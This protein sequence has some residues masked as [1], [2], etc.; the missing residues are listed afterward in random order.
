MDKGCI[1]VDEKKTKNVIDVV[2]LSKD[3]NLLDISLRDNISLG[4]K[5]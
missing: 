2:Y 3:V 4:K 1:L 5:K